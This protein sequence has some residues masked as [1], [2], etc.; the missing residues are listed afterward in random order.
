MFTNIK[1]GVRLPALV[2][3]H[4]CHNSL[5]IGAEWIATSAGFLN[6]DTNEAYGESESLGLKCNNPEDTT[7]LRLFMAGGLDQVIFFVT[8]CAANRESAQAM[9]MRIKK[10]A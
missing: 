1:R 3:A 8:D 6:I 4:V 10:G 7:I 2:S 5:S 9:M